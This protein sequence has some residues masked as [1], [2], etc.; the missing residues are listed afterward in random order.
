MGQPRPEGTKRHHVEE[1]S[2]WT[3]RR[4]AAFIGAQRQRMTGRTGLI[5]AS[6]RDELLATAA[7]EAGRTPAPDKRMP[8]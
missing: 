8:W 1:T 4:P 3:A 6:K 2:K 5:G 7:A